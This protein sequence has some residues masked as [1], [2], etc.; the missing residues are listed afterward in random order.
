MFRKLVPGAPDDDDHS[1]T[2]TPGQPPPTPTYDE[3]DLAI[4]AH[5][6]GLGGG[7]QLLA[8]VF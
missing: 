8:E 4:M 6:E 2:L 7:R 5:I 3:T 1:H